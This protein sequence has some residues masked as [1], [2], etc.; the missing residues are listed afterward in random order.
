MR[1]AGMK[2]SWDPEQR[3]LYLKLKP[4][5][6]SE[7]REMAPGIVFDFDERGAVVGIDIDDVAQTLDIDDAARM[8]A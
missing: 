8:S 4:G 6:T 7:S 3:S 1:Q 5:A 2:V